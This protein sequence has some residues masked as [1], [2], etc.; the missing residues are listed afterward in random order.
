M[1]STLSKH[2]KPVNWL[3]TNSH[4]QAAVPGDKQAMGP[5]LQPHESLASPFPLGSAHSRRLDL[6]GWAER[7]PV[8]DFAHHHSLLTTTSVGWKKGKK[9]KVSS[10]QGI[11]KLFNSCIPMGAKWGFLLHPSP[12]KGWNT[13]WQPRTWPDEE[14]LDGSKKNPP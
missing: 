1:Q 11:D 6:C 2:Q 7:Q 13:P 10:Q 8:S 4:F 12:W 5:C 9:H 3:S 14:S